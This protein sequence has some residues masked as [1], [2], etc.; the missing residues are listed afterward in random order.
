MRSYFR[1]D[2]MYLWSVLVRMSGVKTEK[3]ILKAPLKLV[4]GAGRQPL[5]L[6]PGQDNHTLLRQCFLC[7]RLVALTFVV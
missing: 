3:I 7:K 2:W 1:L 6:H 4:P 5:T